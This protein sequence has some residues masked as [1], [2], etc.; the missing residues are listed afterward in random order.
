M[1]EAK[2]YSLIS[3]HDWR[4][5]FFTPAE[6]ACKADGSL[7]FDEG[8]LTL[9]ESIRILFGRPMIVTSGYRSPA[10]NAKVS[11]TGENGPHTMGR[12][13]DIAVSGQDAAELARIALSHGGIT[14]LGVKQ[15]GTGRFLHLDNLTPA[16]G[17]PRP[18]IW[19]YP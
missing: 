9:L 10:Y 7:R 2:H 16:A 13:V 3:P 1:I 18:R 19:S 5:R 6:L 14:G 15:H 17:F 12:A 8:F 11:T 4:W